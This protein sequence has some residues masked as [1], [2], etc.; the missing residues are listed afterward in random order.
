M[1]R[2][3]L[4]ES[5]FGASTHL[6][7]GKTLGFCAFSGSGRFGSEPNYS[8]TSDSLQRLKALQSF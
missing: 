3:C 5:R 6:S 2:V 7:P 4:K 1:S 8:L